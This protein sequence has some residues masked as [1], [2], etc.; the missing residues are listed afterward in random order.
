MPESVIMPKLAMAMQEG[1][2]VEYLAAEGEW[3]EKGQQVMT[4]ETEKVTYEC[5]APAS[6]YLHIIVEAGRTVPVF[7]AVAL[8][9]ASEEGVL[10]QQVAEPAEAAAAPVPEKETRAERPATAGR[11][12]ISPLAKKLARQHS[13]DLATIV[14]SGPGGRIVKG[15]VEKALAAAP[16]AAVAPVPGGSGERLVR[17][18]LPLTG[19]RKA[20]A[21]HMLHSL[22]VAAQMST[23]GEIDMTEMIRLRETLLD[24]E[25]EI[26]VR[27]SY[28]DLFVLV[29]ARAVRYVPAVNSSLIDGEI[30]IW[31]DVNVGVAVALERGEYESGLIIPVIKNADGKSLLEISRAVK[32]LTA[33]ARTGRLTPEDVEG[34][35]IT[36]SN[37]GMVA[38]RW[39]VSTPI[40]NQPETVIVQP[41]AIVD[42]PSAVAGQ[43]QV[44]PMMTMSITSDHRVLDGVPVTRFFNKIAELVENPAL[45]HL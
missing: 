39:M 8:L 30:K 11:I 40:L 18:T 3:V 38:Q 44:R 24:Q 4:I 31:Q 10:Q 21:D 33:R 37:A 16:P 29:L 28:T 6:G 25:E 13:L 43:V 19:M 42:R 35:T 12:K 9:A 17:A 32:D 7:E 1:T 45:L 5:E 14:G 15:D 23:M 20:I 34:G 22:D 41:G 36:L 2:V 27:I 26:G